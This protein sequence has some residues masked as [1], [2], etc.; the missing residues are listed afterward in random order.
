MKTKYKNL[1]IFTFNFLIS[2]DWKP[3][4]SLFFLFFEFWKFLF[5][6]ILPGKKK[7]K[8][9]S[10]IHKCTAPVFCSEIIQLDEPQI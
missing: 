6:E 1:A 4:K 10:S 9:L 5:G 3:P 7:K 8:T 2:G